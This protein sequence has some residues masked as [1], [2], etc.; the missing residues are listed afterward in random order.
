[1]NTIN[2]STGFSPFQLRMGRSPRIIPPITPL[3]LVDA[4]QE[5]EEEARAAELIDKLALDT[6]EARDNLFA[7]KVSQAEFANRHCASEIPFV[8]G[9]KVL[10]STTHRRHEY[11]QAKSGRVAKFMP[12]FDGPF[13]ITHAYPQTS[14]YT[15]ELPN[16]PNRFPTFH[17]SQI[18]PFIENDNE[19]FR[20]RKLAQPGPVLTSEGQEEWLLRDII[21]E[22]IRG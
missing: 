13:K 10:L 22:R 5:T 1:M 19:L 12:R 17:S 20:A 16:E 8:V 7:A 18:R 4:S 14:T 6:A 2:T 11:V 3:S 21:N 9:D 15:L